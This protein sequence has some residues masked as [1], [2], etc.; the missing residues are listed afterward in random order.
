MNSTQISAALARSPF[1]FTRNLV[2]P[3]VSW[4]MLP[5]EADLLVLTQADFLYEVEIKIS[6]GDVKRDLSKS[7][8]RPQFQHMHDRLI[9]CRWF[10]MPKKL[11]EHK[12]IGVLVPEHAG[13]IAVDP[14]LPRHYAA[15]VVRPAKVNRNARKATIHERAQLARLGTLRYWARGD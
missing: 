11:S 10:A 7:K 14:D 8:W 3:N 15:K 9:R 5:W 1:H 4:G 6:L 13:I 12:D 2:V